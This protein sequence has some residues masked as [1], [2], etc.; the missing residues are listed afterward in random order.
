MRVL[1]DYG[2]IKPFRLTEI[3]RQETPEYRAAAKLLSEGD[4]LAGLEAIERLGWVKE[5]GDED[6]HAHIAADYLQALDDLKALPENKRV[7]VVSPTHAEAARIT[8]KIRSELRQAGKLHGDD[9]GFTRLVAVDTSEAQRGQA[10]TYR[11]GDVLQF[12]QNAKGFKKGERFTV[13]DPAS[14]P[15]DLAARFSLYRPVHDAKLAAGDRIMFTAPVK[16]VAGGHTLKNGMTKTVSD[17]LPDG[18]IRLDNGWV[19]A[20]DA[21]HWNHAYCVTSFASQGKTVQRVILDMASAS[22]GAINQEQLYVSASRGKQWMRVYTDDTDAMKSAVL[23]SS[24]KLAALDL[25]RP[26]R[27][28]V[29]QPAVKPE[30]WHRLRTHLERLRRLAVIDRTRAAWAA[31]TPRP[32]KEKQNERQANAY[33]R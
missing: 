18:N 19:V 31:V 22:R 9:H 20:S 30:R 11:P 10:T 32:K 14:V 6:R 29:A 4:T 3:M 27:G 1:K 28:P 33:S 24:Q 26:E 7:L 16:T 21:G 12:H 5:M 2:C 8:G 23:Q 13:T 25:K 17:I 15:L